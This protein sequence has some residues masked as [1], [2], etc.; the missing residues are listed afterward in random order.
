ML[1]KLQDFEY[2]E[3]TSFSMAVS[4]LE[5][6][7]KESWLLAGGTDLLV[8]MKEGARRSKVLINIKNIPGADQI[9]FDEKEGLKIGALTKISQIDASAVIQERYTPLA[10][11]AKQ[12]A[13]AQVRNLATIGGNLCTASPSAETA[14]PLLA[15]GAKVKLESSKGE[16]IIALEAF[17]T[18]PGSTVLDKEVLTEIQIPTPAPRT[19]GVYKRITRRN[20]VDLAIVGVSVVASISEDAKK[21]ET[22]KIALGAVAPTPMRALKAEAAING[23][24]IA[25]E[26]IEKAALLASEES[27][28]ISDIRGSAWYR[29]EMVK[30]LVRRSLEEISRI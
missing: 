5:K 24:P 8:W 19:R 26:V 11:A 23:K 16:R 27:R 15:L 30:V 2:L 9:T 17:F 12:L 21:W 22:V 18:G 28:P 13:S 3:A 14:S 10:Q 25:P 20:A 4:L 1:R 6:Y 7:G 29:K